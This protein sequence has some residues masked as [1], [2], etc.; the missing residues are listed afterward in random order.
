MV[1]LTRVR[2]NPQRRATWRLQSNLEALH[3][4]VEKGFPTSDHGRVLWRLDSNEVGPVLYVVS[5]SEPDYTGLVEECGWPRLDYGEQVDSTG[6]ND[7]LNSMHGGQRVVFRLRFNSVKAKNHCSKLTSVIGENAIALASSRLEPA[8]DVESIRQV[9]EE[10]PVLVKSGHR[11]NPTILTFE[12]SARVK[13]AGELRR[14][15]T[16]GIGRMKAY[17]CG[18]LTVMPV[19]E[20]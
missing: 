3:A 15:L 14:M 5:E 1:R 2:L 6:Y 13:D 4:A 17:G 18:L 16:A 9:G 19:P 10:H 20:D 8:L 11:F 12:G 7:Y